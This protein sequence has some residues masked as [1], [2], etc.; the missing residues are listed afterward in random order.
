[1]EVPKLR[2]PQARILQALLPVS[3][4]DCVEEWPL[5]VR[6]VMARRAGYSPISGSVT[7]ALMGVKEGSSSMKSGK[8][9]KGL[10]ALGLIETVELDIMGVKETNYR[11]TPLGV[12]AYE[13]FVR[14]GAKIKPVSGDASAH[15]NKR[16]VKSETVG[17]ETPI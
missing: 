1:M 4:D 5:L 12:K 3:E 9:M 8:G 7:R 13:Q 17:T 15:T 14:S 10:M 6:A 16:Y 11:I 2:V